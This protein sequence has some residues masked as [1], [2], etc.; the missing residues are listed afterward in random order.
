[1]RAELLIL[2]RLS[3]Q[4][5]NDTLPRL[6]LVFGQETSSRHFFLYEEARLLQRKV[7]RFG[8]R[9]FGCETLLCGRS[10]EYLS[11]IVLKG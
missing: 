1:M 9:V 6:C 7:G 4:I 10:D 5:L 2:R 8:E 3:A 11:F